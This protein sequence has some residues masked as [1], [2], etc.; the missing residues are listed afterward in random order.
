MAKWEEDI[1]AHFEEASRTSFGSITVI[2]GK[3][4]TSSDFPAAEVL[5][6]Q[7]CGEFGEAD[8]DAY[9]RLHHSYV[10][11]RVKCKW[12]NLF[13]LVYDMRCYETPKSWSV[14]ME[15]VMAFVVM[16]Q[17]LGDLYKQYLYHTIVMCAHN[18]PV[19]H[20]R[21]LVASF[22]DQHTRPVIM[23]TADDGPLCGMS[24]YT[25]STRVEGMRDACGAPADAIRQ[26][27][28]DA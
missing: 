11:H 1:D 12:P 14:M 15:R 9:V 26:D 27:H 16:H 17:H 18:H 8:L 4:R 19:D 23:H 10:M 7:C 20:I 22:C 13:M 25:K 21:R 24:S 6:V 2:L 3:R 5:Y 28:H